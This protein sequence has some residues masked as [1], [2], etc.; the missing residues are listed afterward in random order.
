MQAL[1]LAAT[2]LVAQTYGGTYQRVQGNFPLN[3]N[4]SNYATTAGSTQNV[5]AGGNV[6][7]N[8]VNAN[9]VNVPAANGNATFGYD[10]TNGGPYLALLGNEL[11]WCNASQCTVIP[12]KLQ[13]G[14]SGFSAI[15]FG[16]PT[17]AG[18]LQLISSV[19]NLALKG[20]DGVAFKNF[21]VQQVYANNQS[22]T[23]GAFVSNNAGGGYGFG[24]ADITHTNIYTNG[25]S[26]LSIDSSQNATFSQS[27]I[28]AGTGSATAPALQLNSGGTGVLGW[29]SVGNLNQSYQA[30]GLTQNGAKILTLDMLGGSLQFN[31][32]GAASGGYQ[33][34]V[35]SAQTV[36]VS[37][38]ST[39]GV[40]AV[41]GGFAAAPQGGINVPN[42]GAVLW[43]GPA[44]HSEYGV[45]NSTTQISG[46]LSGATAS[47]AGA[48]PAGS[49]VVGVV[50]RVT[51][52]ITGA[53]SF[54]IGDG[55]TATA[56]G[57]NIAVASG[58]TTTNANWTLTAI[59]NYPSGANIVLTANG[60]NF[61]GGVVRVTVYYMSFGAPTN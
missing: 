15:Q 32:A 29:Y 58:T 24:F 33:L 28:T 4:T 56:F 3:A 41:Q 30:L 31:V 50:A 44:T 26:A 9:V 23:A 54:S 42:A 52:A 53:T 12:S 48:I 7:T 8:A 49:V 40:R 55:T 1:I 22:A 39:G 25:A 47:F 34:Y 11:L 36:V 37:A 14:S 20:G 61:T 6:V 13:V 57:S 5:V 45:L 43:Q 35:N 19:N 16:L 27:V 17:S 46:A 51:T 2:L 21:D 60:G 38:G 59:P 10:A 18:G